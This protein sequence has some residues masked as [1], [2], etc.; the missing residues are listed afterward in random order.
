MTGMPGKFFFLSIS[1]YMALPVQGFS[2]QHCATDY[3][4]Q[5]QLKKDTGYAR[6]HGRF[7]RQMAYSITAQRIGFISFPDSV[8][9]I[10]VVVHIIHNNTSGNIGG[11][12]ISD[13]QIASQIKVLNEDYRRLNADTSLTRSM[14]KP[15][16]GDPKFQFCL[17]NKD[18]NGNYTT[19]I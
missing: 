11:L 1:I 15:V 5:Q 16:T 17:A 2:Q 4:H 10:P 19:G 7:M 6:T 13:E 8:Y 3:I 12:N 18:P 9:T 14:F